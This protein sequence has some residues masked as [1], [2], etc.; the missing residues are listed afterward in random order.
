MLLS[1]DGD[2][3]ESPWDVPYQSATTNQ[4]STDIEESLKSFKPKNSELVGCL[5]VLFHQ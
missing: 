2:T 3:D 1:V 5:F 4:Y